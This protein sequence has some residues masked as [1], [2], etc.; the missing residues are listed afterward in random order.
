LQIATALNGL[1]DKYQ[2]HVFWCTPEVLHRKAK[3]S[4]RWL[5]VLSHDLAA[6]PKCRNYNTLAGAGDI[7]R[8]CSQQNHHLFCIESFFYRLRIQNSVYKN[9]IKEKRT[10]HASAL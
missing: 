6:S 9:K 10:N 4:T 2:P 7:T 3:F 5:S 1:Y 8:G